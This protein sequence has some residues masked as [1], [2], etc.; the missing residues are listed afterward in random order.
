MNPAY[1][2]CISSMCPVFYMLSH[3]WENVSLLAR[4]DRKDSQLVILE[5]TLDEDEGDFQ[6]HKPK[7]FKRDPWHNNLVIFIRCYFI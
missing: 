1:L 4:W 6:A 3:V 7:S 2:R 5:T